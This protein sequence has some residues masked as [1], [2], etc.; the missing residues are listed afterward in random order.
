MLCLPSLIYLIISLLSLVG[1]LN[2]HNIQLM[3]IL[4]SFLF[5]IFWTWLLNYLCYKRYEALSWVLLFLPIIFF[6]LVVAIAFETAAYSK[7]KQTTQGF[8]THR[9]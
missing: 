7:K 3:S 2:Y 6:F 8:Q 1:S 4:L 5:I 9:N